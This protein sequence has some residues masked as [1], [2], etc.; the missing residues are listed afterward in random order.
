MHSG[1]CTKLASELHLLRVTNL[2]T[3][4]IFFI[5]RT[6]Q[7]VVQVPKNLT[8]TGTHVLVTVMKRIICNFLVRRSK[9]ASRE[10]RGIAINKEQTFPNETKEYLKVQ[11]ALKFTTRFDTKVLAS[12]KQFSYKSAL[13]QLNQRIHGIRLR[14]SARTCGARARTFAWSRP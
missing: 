8:G 7:I 2:K 5:V 1:N 12:E 4:Q 6:T 3:V 10:T 13:D 9:I 11:I 14:V